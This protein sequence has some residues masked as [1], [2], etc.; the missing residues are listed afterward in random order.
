MYARLENDKLVYAPR[1]YN[2]GSNL[3]LNFNKNTSIMKQHGFKE[4]IDNKPEYDNSTYYLSISGYTENENNITIIYTLNTIEENQ[5]PTLDEKV[6]SLE[7]EALNLLSTDL[8]FDF[9]IMEIEIIIGQSINLNKNREVKNMARTPYEMMKIL[10]LN[11]KYER[12]DMVN[13]I[14]VYSER[15]KITLKQ[16]KELL[17]LIEANDSRE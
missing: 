13:K 15:A 5:E 9:R 1:N 14:N 10:I 6:K 17:D 8:E 7:S 16:K 11:E 12:E 4:V 3:I 2:T